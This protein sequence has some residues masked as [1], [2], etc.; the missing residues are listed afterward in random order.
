M[1]IFLFLAA[2]PD[3]LQLGEKTLLGGTADVLQST[4]S[5]TAR[6]PACAQYLRATALLAD[7]TRDQS[8][9]A[10]KILDALKGEPPALADW[11]AFRRGEAML[12]QKKHGTITVSH[13]FGWAAQA[14][15]LALAL[16]KPPKEAVNE[17][18]ALK[19]DDK[20][21]Q[22]VLELAAQIETPMRQEVKRDLFVHFPDSK[23]APLF[24]PPATVADLRARAEVLSDKHMNSDVLKTVH[25]AMGM[26]PSPTDV[27]A[28]R[29]YEGAA[30]RKLRHYK[31]AEDA[32]LPVK[33]TC[34]GNEFQKR[35]WFLLGQVQLIADSPAVAEKTMTDFGLTFAGDALADDALFA[36]AQA[37]DKAGDKPRAEAL[38]QKVAAIEPPGDQCAEAS[39]RA[40]YMR[41][42][43]SDFEGARDRF[44]HIAA[45]ERCSDDYERARGMYWL[46][47]SLAQI[48]TP[49]PTTGA[50]SL[51][52]DEAKALLRRLI[53][54]QPLS[55]YSLLARS[56][57]GDTTPVKAPAAS[58]PT[59][60]PALLKHPSARRARA[61]AS[62]G[63]YLEAQA[64]LSALSPGSD[65]LDY[66]ALQAEAFDFYHSHLLVRTQLK[67]TLGTQPSSDNL[68]AW[69]L[70]YPRPFAAQISSAELQQG[71][72]V[73]FLLS[74]IRE[75][76]A[77]MLDVGSWANAFGLTQ[78]L[79]S[80][81]EETAKDLAAHG[82]PIGRVI[83][84]D[85]LKTDVSLALTLGGHQLAMLQR[86]HSSPALVLAA[87]NAGPGSVRRWQGQRGQKPADEFI[88]EIPLDETRGYV[89][90]IYR[91]WAVYR[92]LSGNLLPTLAADQP[93]H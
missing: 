76:S 16:E 44:S 22:Y 6:A 31:P 93:L 51:P 39:F 69:Q 21:R 27:C 42:A 45:G 75:E 70:A 12:R 50:A 90:R 52:A 78:L 66:A 48:R 87:Y 68:N 17:I 84:A 47:R 73:D 58:Q 5:L 41:Y 33:E 86:A 83:D 56:R 49:L 38:Y 79:V 2:T 10:L 40:A 61:L 77:F 65:L 43:E 7:K 8:K 32:L 81:A 36:I 15:A 89:K 64:E 19:G 55:Y 13:D 30:Q 9:D 37:A 24:F 4:A 11:I 88:E 60:T 14:R 18:V 1:L 82:K 26:S 67:A 85:A 91:T 74:L 71:L 92:T 57:L 23:L 80:T 20:A 62:I 63:L 29:F 54:E 59:T 3:C 28:L 34:A 53:D 46:S 25:A 72:P 35:A